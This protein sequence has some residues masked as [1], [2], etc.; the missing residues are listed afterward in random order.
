MVGSGRRV[1]D[2]IRSLD[3]AKDLQLECPRNL[4]ESLLVPFHTYSSEKMLW[5]EKERSRIRAVHTNNL[6]GLLG[7][8]RMD[9]IPNARITEFCGVMKGAEKRIDEG[10]LRWFGHLERME[11]DRIA[12]SVYVREC[13]GSR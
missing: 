10:V 12:K 4:H 6:R 2:A 3:N 11:K 13:A 8:R 9:K 5:K 1:A 7:I